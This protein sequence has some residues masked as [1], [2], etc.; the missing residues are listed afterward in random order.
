MKKF[1]YIITFAFLLLAVTPRATLAS[2][3][4]FS[5]P[6]QHFKTGDKIYF[7]IFLDTEGKN[8]NAVEAEIIFPS[9]FLEFVDYFDT[10]SIINGWV[11]TPALNG[12]SIRFAGIAAG[13]FS[14]LID[15][16]TNSVSSGRVTRLVFVAK[17]EGKGS[18][19]F[20]SADTFLNDGLGTRGVTKTLPYEFMIS[21]EGFSVDDFSF[22]TNPP[23]PFT[24]LVKRDNRF[25]DGKYFVVF[26]AKDKET[27]IASYRIKEGSSS[28]IS[29]KSPYLLQDQSLKST[30]RVIAVDKN[31]NEREAKIKFGNNLVS[32]LGLGVLIG[33]CALLI[34]V[35]IFAYVYTRKKE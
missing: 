19:T 18:L 11:E 27:G 22:D 16:V 30:I 8:T 34:G 33:L 12:N 2:E 17:S 32:M 9:E 10:G 31:G 25:F 15:P 24:L 23:E 1:F 13:G 7:D 6:T 21:N 5:S 20:T 35:S 14:G 4:Y 28:W 29:A 3:I 26:D